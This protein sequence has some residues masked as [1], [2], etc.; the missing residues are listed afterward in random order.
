MSSTYKLLVLIFALWLSQ[1][2][3]VLNKLLVTDPLAQCLDGS[4][5]A[6]YIH[7][8]DKSRFVINFEGGGWC[9]DSRG[10]S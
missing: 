8:G 3:N 9:G 2:A 6:Y 7:P 5:V 1:S 4:A 10:V